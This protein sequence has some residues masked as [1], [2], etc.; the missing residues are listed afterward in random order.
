MHLS[1]GVLRI[2][3]RAFPRHSW[4]SLALSL[5]LCFAVTAILTGCSTV[6]VYV[7]E[8]WED[9]V[10]R[11]AQEQ[12]IYSLRL[13]R[14]TDDVPEDALLRIDTNSNLSVKLI[15]SD[16]ELDHGRLEPQFADAPVMAM[17]I[18]TG[19]DSFIVGWV[20]DTVKGDVATVT[21]GRY[22]ADSE[23]RPVSGSLKTWQTDEG[24]R[25]FMIPIFGSERQL[26]QTIEEIY[27]NTD[28][29]LAAFAQNR[30]ALPAFELHYT[31]FTTLEPYRI[32]T[33]IQP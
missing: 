15:Y 8:A 22:V 19:E 10:D 30:H 3:K 12:G 18:D 16:V 25:L 11:G 7:K 5:A 6:S 9:R 4:L 27:I 28:A 17:Y 23:H 14:W 32:D 31:L 24:S 1:N 13:S 26:W 21:F 29:S 20:D 33:S 2:L